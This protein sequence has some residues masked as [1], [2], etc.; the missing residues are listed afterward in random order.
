MKTTGLV[1]CRFGCASG[2]MTN[3]SAKSN[4]LAAVGFILMASAMFAGTGLLAKALGHDTLGRPMHAFQISHGRFLFA[5]LV[6]LIAVAIIR[7]KFETVNL[8]LHVGRSFLGWA[9]ATL[10]FASVAFIPLP[11]ATAISFLNPVFAMMLAIPLLGEKVGPIRW[12]AAVLALIGA[13]VLIR[14]TPD[15]FQPAAFLALGA[16]VIMGLEVILIKMLTGREKPLQILLINNAIGLTFATVAVIFVW[17]TPTLAQW[18]ALAG[19]GAMMALGQAFFIQAMRRADASFVLPFAYAT[20]IFATFYDYLVFA[21]IPDLI[22]I[23]GAAIIIAGAL[24][25][26]WRE[27]RL[28]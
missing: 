1:K 28:R 18:G 5:F 15:T 6:F 14:P 21:S 7:P 4:P 16:A 13:L 26:A 19:L 24:I 8:G 2:E 10:L 23:L 20:L 9:G 3:H 11:D 17:Q 12:G 27:A 25:L 22:S